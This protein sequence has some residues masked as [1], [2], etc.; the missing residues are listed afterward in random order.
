V[1]ELTVNTN[2]MATGLTQ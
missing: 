1:G 2:K